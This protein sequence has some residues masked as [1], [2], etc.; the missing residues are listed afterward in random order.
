M[1]QLALIVIVRDGID[2]ET[3]ARAGIGERELDRAIAAEQDE[4][5]RQ[6]RQIGRAAPDREQPEQRDEHKGD[7]LVHDAEQVAGIDRAE[8]DQQRDQRD[9]RDRLAAGAVPPEIPDRREE[10]HLRAERARRE[11]E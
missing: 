3:A 2:T 5:A 9:Q 4:A 7:L 8:P 10:E 6:R 11:D 1:R